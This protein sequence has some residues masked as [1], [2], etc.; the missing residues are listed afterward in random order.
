MLATLDVS[1]LAKSG[2]S[3]TCHTI[4]GT[5]PNDVIRS[6]SISSSARSA[7]QRYMRTSFVPNASVAHERR[8][9]AGD[10]EERDGQ[11]LRRPRRVGVRR[12]PPPAP[13]PRLIAPIHEV[14]EVRADV[15]V[16]A[17]RALRVT[18]S[19]RTCRRSSRRPRDRS[20]TSGGASPSP[21]RAARR[22]RPCPAARRHLRDDDV[23]DGQLG[24]MCGSTRSKRS[25]SA[26]E[27]LRARVVEAVRELVARPPRVQRDD[28]RA[29]TRRPPRTR[30]TTRGSS[31]SRSATRSPF[32]TPASSTQPVAT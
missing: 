23:L 3:S 11:Q 24:T 28:D 13:T 15:A 12:S 19:C 18:R 31:A 20:S 8:V 10:V 25:M 21:R 6:R 14:E 22:T 4:V 5:P 30:P 26:N 9:A 32:V 29:G 17:E 7:S 27:H 2:D 1:R 16:R